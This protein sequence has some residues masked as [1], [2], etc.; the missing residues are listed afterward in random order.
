MLLLVLSWDAILWFEL[1]EGLMVYQDRSK[2]GFGKNIYLDIIDPCRKPYAS[3]EQ[4][5]ININ[6]SYVHSQILIRHRKA[7]WT[8]E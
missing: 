6:I 7:L 1:L 5:K 3:R 4:A 2:Y 8:T